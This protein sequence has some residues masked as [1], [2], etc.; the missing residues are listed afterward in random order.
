MQGVVFRRCVG[1]HRFTGDGDLSRNDDRAHAVRQVNVHP[2]AETDQSETLTG[3]DMVAFPGESQDS[4]RHQTG[5]LDDG[6]VVSFSGW[7]RRLRR[8][9]NSLAL[10][11]DAL[12]KRPG[13]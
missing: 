9:L 11:R 8:S 3:F 13:R 10:S 7:M 2:A 6:D 1:D 4:S 12:I 5:D